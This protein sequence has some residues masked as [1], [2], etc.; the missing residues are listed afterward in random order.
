MDK[1]EEY[2]IRRF[3]DLFRRSYGTGTWM[4]TDFLSAGDAALV[5]RVAGETEVSLFGGAEGCERVMIRFGNAE[6][7]G[8]EIPFPIR[9]LKVAPLQKK[10][11][12]ELT[13]RDFL[14]ALM[15]LG[16]ERDVLGDIVVKTDHAYVF[17]AEKIADFIT[18]NLFRIKHTSVTVTVIQDVPEDV[19]PT[20]ERVEVIVPSLR[21]DGI[22][23][24]LYHLSRQQAKDLFTGGLVLVNGRLCMNPA[25]AVKENDILSV[26]GHGKFAFRRFD[27]ETK[28]GNRVVVVEK[29]V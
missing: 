14:G 11:A 29:Y 20:L 9:I 12:D 17:A 28:K 19:A 16:I 23:A 10:F 15:N 7:F 25:G 2:L 26:R 18:E 22:V 3:E 21:L 5:Y 13:H 8:Y 27:H 24:K 6:E 1:N 4:F